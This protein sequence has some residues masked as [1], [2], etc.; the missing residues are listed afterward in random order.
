[1]PTDIFVTRW[2]GIGDVLMALCAA[3]AYRAVNGGEVY[4]WT[5]PALRPLAACCPWVNVL[6]SFPADPVL[7]AIDLSDCS[8]GLGAEH[9]VD[10]MCRRLGLTEVLPIH[11]SLDLEIPA[12][13]SQILHDA[14]ARND[15]RD[16]VIL[17]HPGVTDPNR[18]W[19]A[20]HWVELAQRLLVDGHIVALIGGEK[21]GQPLDF[22]GLSMPRTARFTNLIGRLSLLETVQAMR[23]ASVVVSSDAGPVQLAGASEAA[24]VGL[25]SVVSGAHRAPYRHGRMG[26]RFRS[27]PPSCHHF[28]CYPEIRDPAVWPVERDRLLSEGHNTLGRQLG[29]WCLRPAR[30][31]FACMRTELTP[32]RVYSAVREMLEDLL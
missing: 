31:R 27:V 20:S 14:F 8:H 24:V 16:S 15:D 25:Y 17:L 11:K 13:P 18:T 6:E 23:M 5:A 29:N 9:E 7:P 19:P 4:F 1:M 21:E 10:S 30:D 3:H 26:W 2:S 32:A 28:P 22:S 12:A